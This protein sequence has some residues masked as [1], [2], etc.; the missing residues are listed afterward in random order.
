MS[1]VQ[2]TLL[3]Q[4]TP[5][6]DKALKIRAG[7]LWR[8]QG[9]YNLTVVYCDYS[10]ASTTLDYAAGKRTRERM[11]STLDIVDIQSYSKHG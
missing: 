11:S 1:E 5:A 2:I 9:D 6:T 4:A 7:M 3:E 8:F 10:F